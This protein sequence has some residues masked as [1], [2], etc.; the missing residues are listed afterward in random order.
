MTTQLEAVIASNEATEPEYR[1]PTEGLE[2]EGAIILRFQKIM[3]RVKGENYATWV[4][5]AQRD[6]ELHPFVVWNLIARPEGWV[7]E[8]GDYYADHL[9]AEAKYESRAF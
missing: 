1:I 5:M 2:I 7:Y 9:E 3:E 6:H 4:V 8:S